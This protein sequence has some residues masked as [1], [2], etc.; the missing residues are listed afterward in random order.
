MAAEVPSPGA[1]DAHREDRE[2]AV[3]PTQELRIG[4][5]SQGRQHG[6]RLHLLQGTE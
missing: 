3:C 6:A 4:R 5:G 2:R 1:E